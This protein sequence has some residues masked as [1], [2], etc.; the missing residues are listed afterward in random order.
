MQ[1]KLLEFLGEEEQTLR[2]V[3]NL[4]K[5]KPIKSVI[6]LHGFERCSTTEKKFKALADH[7]AEKGVASLRLDFSGCGLSDGDFIATTITRQS[8]EFL[9]A[10]PIF[11]QEMGNEKINIVAHSLGACVLAGVIEK[12]KSRLEK[13]ILLAPALNQKELL[14][15][16][17]VTSQMKKM[18]AEEE[19]TWQ[20]YRQNLDEEA[21]ET[22][23]SRADKMTKANYIGADYFLEGKEVDFSEIFREYDSRILHIH[24]LKDVAVPLE[25]LS[26]EFS[27][28]IMVENGD[29]DLEK[30]NQ[31]DQ[32]LSKARDFL[33]QK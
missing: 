2:G 4:P 18:R 1:T 3:L 13:I 9:K 12:I 20:N 32:W 5:E 24:G 27:N 33:C 17:F 6:F 22:D 10:I 8:G 15:Y 29:H 25:S 30:P 26:F 14:R 16:W 7:L 21:F 28:K 31:R 23:C 19:T 11:L